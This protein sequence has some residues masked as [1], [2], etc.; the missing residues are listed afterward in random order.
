MWLKHYF[1][2]E[3]PNMSLIMPHLN[4]TQSTESNKNRD[5]FPCAGGCLMVTLQIVYLRNVS[6][7]L[8]RSNETQTSVLEVQ[9]TIN[10]PRY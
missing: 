4:E 5:S 10:D 2:K 9:C 6:H 8:H 3:N 7:H 1:V